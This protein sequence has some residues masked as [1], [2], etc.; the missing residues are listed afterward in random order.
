MT[1]VSGP[2]RRSVLLYPRLPKIPDIIG[3]RLARETREG[4][5]ASPFT[6]KKQHGRAAAKRSR[7]EPHKAPPTA[8]RWRRISA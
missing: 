1:Q 4:S 6:N 8:R 7:N 3:C 5:I 2:R